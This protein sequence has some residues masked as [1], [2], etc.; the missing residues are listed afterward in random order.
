MDAEFYVDFKNIKLPLDKM[1][2]KKGIPK[3]HA[4]FRLI[5]EKSQLSTFIITFVGAFSHLGMF[6]F[7]KPM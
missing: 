7:L 5:Q 4:K 2:L 6:I 1:H 3:K